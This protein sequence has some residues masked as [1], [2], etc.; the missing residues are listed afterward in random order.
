MYYYTCTCVHYITMYGMIK[1]I[2]IFFLLR[3]VYSFTVH[4]SSLPES[5]IGEICKGAL[6]VSK[7]CY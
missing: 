3:I 7:T 2:G 4:K 1:L 5:E 6:L